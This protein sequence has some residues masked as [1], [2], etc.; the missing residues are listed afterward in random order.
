MSNLC[1]EELPS[2]RPLGSAAPRHTSGRPLGSG[3]PWD[4]AVTCFQQG[5]L[6]LLLPVSRFSAVNRGC[7][8]ETCSGA[9]VPTP[10]RGTRPF[11]GLCTPP[12][13]LWSFPVLL[14]L[15]FFWHSGDLCH[16]PHLHPPWQMSRDLCPLLFPSGA[17]ELAE[18]DNSFGSALGTASEQDANP[19]RET[20]V[21]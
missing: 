6:T 10:F 4:S 17:W 5:V 19:M 2:P 20:N 9:A 12:G 8:C 16:T 7:I 14:Q 15:S 3:F 13:T 11:L 21:F 18:E 1:Q